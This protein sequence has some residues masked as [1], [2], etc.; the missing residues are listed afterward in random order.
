MKFTYQTVDKLNLDKMKTFVF[1][2][3]HGNASVTL[4]ANDFDEAE[5]ALFDIVQGD[6]GWRVEDEEGEPEE[7]Y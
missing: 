7:E 4:S 3:K 1:Y 5:E 2:Q 6:C